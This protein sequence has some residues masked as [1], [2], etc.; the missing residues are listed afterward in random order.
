MKYDEHGYITELDDN[1]IFVFASN[2]AGKHGSGSAQTAFLKFGAIWDKGEGRFGQSYAFPTLSEN[3]E[4][5][6]YFELERSVTLLQKSVRIELYRCAEYRKYN[7]F[8]QTYIMTKIGCGAAGYP[9]WFMKGLFQN[10]PI[11][12]EPNIIWPADWK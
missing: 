9:E 7:L 4:Q 6:P 8:K 5:L 2:R 3:R 1:E 10:H 12:K 11:W